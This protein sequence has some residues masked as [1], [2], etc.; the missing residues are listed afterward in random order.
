[1]KI[2]ISATYQDLRRHR[3]AVS[4]VLRRMGHQVFGM[5]EYVAEGLRPLDRCLADVKSCDAYVGIF[6]WRY[7]YV[8]QTAGTADMAAPPGT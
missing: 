5:E 4:L 3:E 7:G 6:G 2:Y 1:M 8:P